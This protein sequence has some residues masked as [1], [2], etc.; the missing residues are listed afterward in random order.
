[1]S[2]NFKI[3]TKLSVEKYIEVVENL[4]DGYFGINGEYIPHMGK[5]NAIRIFYNYCV[6][7]T[8]LDLPEKIVDELECIDKLVSNE[9]FM[10]AYNGELNQVYGRNLDFGNAIFDAE[11]SVRIKARSNNDAFTNLINSI[12]RLTENMGN[13]LTPETAKALIK[14]SNDI[15]EGKLNPNNIVESMYQK[16]IKQTK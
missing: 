15:T 8:T 14:I 16:E 3:N 12:S 1:M 10:T 7:E 11:E 4:I 5:I 13:T 9:E 2:E 6:E